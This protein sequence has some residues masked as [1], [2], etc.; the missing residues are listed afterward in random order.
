MKNYVLAVIV[1]I[2]LI[3][4]KKGSNSS[5]TAPS[6]TAPS[7]DYGALTLSGTGSNTTG[8]KFSPT[9]VEFAASATDYKWM[10]TSFPLSGGQIEVVKFTS[11]LGTQF[12]VTFAYVTS[13]TVTWSNSKASGV[14]INTSTVT[15]NNVTLPGEMN[16][17][18]SLTL[19]GTLK[20]Q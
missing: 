18:T 10:T 6:P 12:I 13:P 15:F 7:I 2:M 16:T 3:A 4:C 19:N 8:T 17:T 1:L 14:T 5:P 11:V 9:K 20:F